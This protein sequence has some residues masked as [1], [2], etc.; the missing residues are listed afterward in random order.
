MAC[1]ML[2]LARKEFFKLVLA[3]KEGYHQ[4][5]RFWR[6][7]CND[8]DSDVYDYSSAITIGKNRPW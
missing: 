5:Y 3:V 2:A 1:C 7:R 8:H 6:S 4:K